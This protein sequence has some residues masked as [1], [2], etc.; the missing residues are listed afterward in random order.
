MP[1]KAVAMQ[2][3]RQQATRERPRGVGT[4]NKPKEEG[5]DQAQ[6]KEQHCF[7]CGAPGQLRAECRKNLFLTGASRMRKRPHCS[8]ATCTSDILTLMLLPWQQTLIFISG[9]SVQ[10]V[11][12]DCSSGCTWKRDT[13]PTERRESREHVSQTC[14]FQTQRTTS[15]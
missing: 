12:S 7:Y 5:S 13:A 11:M 8:N 2:N 9:V 1:R 3:C 15:G 14:F 10:F 6:K 4:N